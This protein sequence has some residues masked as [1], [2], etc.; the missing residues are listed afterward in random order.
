M[1][2]APGQVTA[3]AKPVATAVPPRFKTSTPTAVAG[4]LTLT[5]AAWRQRTRCW[6]S[7]AGDVAVGR[8]QTNR[9]QTCTFFKPSPSRLQNHTVR[10]RAVRPKRGE[11]LD[12]KGPP[13]NR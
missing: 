3:N 6:A 7:S 2:P 1:L 8:R 11:E 10:K 9:A 5:T 12:A 4:G 13:G